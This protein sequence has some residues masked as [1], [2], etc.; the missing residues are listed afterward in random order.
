MSCA[1]HRGHHGRQDAAAAPNVQDVLAGSQVQ[2]LH[3][4][5]V[6]VWCADV[7]AQVQRQRHVCASALLETAA[8]PA[9]SSAQAGSALSAH[10][11]E[12]K[13]A[14]RAPANAVS[15]PGSFSGTN[16]SRG[17]R[18]IACTSAGLQTRPELRLAANGSSCSRAAPQTHVRRVS[19]RRR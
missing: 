12:D 5:R 10:T 3:A 7:E 9:V 6:H 19:W 8:C 15:L 18:R 13:S 16:T 2:G 17:Q 11:E 4:G 14:C 1:H